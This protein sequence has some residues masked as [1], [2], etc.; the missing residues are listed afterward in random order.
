VSQHYSDYRQDDKHALPDVEVFEMTARETAEHCR[1]KGSSA[2]E[3]A[4]Y[5]YMKRPEFRLAG[6]NS[7]IRD[8]MFDTMIEEECIEGGWFYWF[9]FPGCLPD[10]EPFGPYKTR[11]EAIAAAQ[12]T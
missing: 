10:S 1:W 6:M 11:A 9:C 7:R 12:T 3:D 2:W 8:A 4:I 5:E